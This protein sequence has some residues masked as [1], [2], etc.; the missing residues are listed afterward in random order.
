VKRPLVLV[1]DDEPASLKL[2]RLALDDDYEVVTAADAEQALA[3]LE[4]A[5]PVLVLLD[6]ELPDI[7]GI[8]LAR[9]IKRN[10]L[11]R[12]AIVIALSAH[13]DRGR[14]DQARAAGCAAYL[15]KPVDPGALPAALAGYLAPARVSS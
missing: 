5:R 8:E 7:D 15:Q 9:H 2:V 6:L 13:R 1:V 3:V 11:C 12:N 4:M 10:P 14:E